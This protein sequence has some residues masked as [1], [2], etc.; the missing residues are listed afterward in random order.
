MPRLFLSFC[1]LSSEVAVLHWNLGRQNNY[2][3]AGAAEVPGGDLFITVQHAIW[4]KL[5][6]FYT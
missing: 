6:C 3:W 4:N 5:I 1:T 2:F